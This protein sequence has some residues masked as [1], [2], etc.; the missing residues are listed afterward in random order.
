MDTQSVLNPYKGILLSLKREEVV[1]HV[2]ARVRLEDTAVKWANQKMT[3][4]AWFHI[5]GI[6][7]KATVMDRVQCWFGAG[8]GGEWRGS[9]LAG[10]EFQFCK[11]I[12]QQCECIW[13]HWTVHL[14]MRKMAH[15]MLYIVSV[16]ACQVASVMSDSLW[17]FGNI[18]HQIL[19]HMGFSRQGYWNGLPCPPPGDLPNPGSEPESVSWIGRRIFFTTCATREAHVYF[20]P[21]LKKK[22]IGLECWVKEFLDDFNC[23]FVVLLFQHNG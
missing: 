18:A 22:E 4:T 9:C 14:R 8:G 13:C 16:R 1:R 10:T 11:M 6:L 2:T 19:L 15:F 3:S 17:P 21:I 23:T 5:H 12:A 7:R 20:T